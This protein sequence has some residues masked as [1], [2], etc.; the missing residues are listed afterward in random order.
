M[1]FKVIHI[2]K[3]KSTDYSVGKRG[4]GGG[5]SGRELSEEWNRSTKLTLIHFTNSFEILVKK[6]RWLSVFI[7]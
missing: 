1:Y 7:K 3:M 5:Y 6:K 2:Q 4:I